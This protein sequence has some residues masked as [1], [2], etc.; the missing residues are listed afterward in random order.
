MLV[1]DK[2]LNSRKAEL[3][4][5]FRDRASESLQE[6]RRNYG[7][8]EFKHQAIATN[9]A[10]L[11]AGKTVIEALT[12]RATR[13]NWTNQEILPNVSMITYTTYVVLLESRNEVWPYEYM[14]FSR[15]IG[16]LWE[17]FCKLC[18]RYPITPINLFAPPLFP[19]S[20]GSSQTKSK[21]I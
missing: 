3:L 17:P 5:Y 20:S 9:K 7:A 21:V 11:E 6:V 19:R 1:I 14:A 12:Q 18:F 13:E 2:T 15:R 4:S 8:T 16:E 10:V